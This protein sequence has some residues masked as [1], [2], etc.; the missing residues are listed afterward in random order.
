MG[1][2]TIGR[3]GTDAALIRYGS[4]AID[5]LDTR[6][7][8]YIITRLRLVTIVITIPLALGLAFLA[9]IVAVHVFD[10][11]DL[12]NVVVTA[13]LI[14]PLF[15]L[16]FVQSAGF[17]VLRRP[18]LAPFSELGAASFCASA[19]LIIAMF[20]AVP[21]SATLALAMLGLAICATLLIG[22]VL[23]RLQMRGLTDDRGETSPDFIPPEILS[24]L[25]DFALPAL[26]VYGTNWGILLFVGA[27]TTSEEVAL[28]AVSLRLMLLVNI[29][30]TV[31]LTVII[32]SFAPLYARNETAALARLVRR[33]AFAST[34]AAVPAAALIC[35]TPGFW[36][37]FFGI[38][39]G[40]SAFVVFIL[41]AAQ[42]FNA[43]FG[44]VGEILNA[45]GY[46]KKMRN[47]VICVGG[48][49]I[50]LAYPII[51]VFGVK[52]AALLVFFMVVAQ[53]TIATLLVRR[54]LD[55]WVFPSWSK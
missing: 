29:A 38:E 35:V 9:P 41:M 52:G 16:M 47:V 31:I 45:A 40:T 2:G 53:N 48:P 39:L 17:K 19:A 30:S 51:D 23:E 37:S 13:A 22:G 49:V 11:P 34:A 14:S 54:N 55:F 36:L 43:T 3:F 26:I 25:P 44:P 15:P 27:L 21:P 5:T 6:A 28:F 50:I 7:L 10:T 46:A 32:P 18:E 42:L 4:L 12:K 33:A 1:L 20:L 8:K 24:K